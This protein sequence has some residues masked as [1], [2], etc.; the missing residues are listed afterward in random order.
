[1]HVY[2]HNFLS[3]EQEQVQRYSRKN[4]NITGHESI[5]RMIYTFSNLQIVK[6]IDVLQSTSDMQ[7]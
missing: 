3:I 1:M 6:R 4:K 5:K 2:I 7:L